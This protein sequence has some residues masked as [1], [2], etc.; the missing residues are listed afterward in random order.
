MFMLN[1][2][3]Q[4][5]RPG[6]PNKS[7]RFSGPASA[8]PLDQ[9]VNWL[10]LKGGIPAEPDPSGRFDPE[11]NNLWDDL[12]PHG[13]LVIP[14][15]AP[16]PAGQFDPANVAFRVAPGLAGVPATAQLQ[17]IVSFGRPVIS[18]RTPQAS[19]FT[20][21]NTP[22]GT[23]KTAFVFPFA[24]MNTS[25]GWFFRLGRIAVRPPTSV[26]T[27]GVLNDRYEFSVG[28]IISPSGDTIN[29][30]FQYFGEDPEVD[31]GQ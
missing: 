5:T 20:D 31:V 30:P 4:I 22:N 1:M 6:T 8:A 21:D 18:A 2:L 24:P 23:V 17:L 25:A 9:S 26:S 13:A 19:P 7:G 15:F 11:H 10:R 27:A 28:A 12:G 3:F 16:I 29:G 14:N